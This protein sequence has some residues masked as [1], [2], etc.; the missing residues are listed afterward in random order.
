[1]PSN[2]SAL[3][4]MFKDVHARSRKLLRSHI[5]AGD[6]K[7]REIMDIS[8]RDQPTSDYPFVF[9]YAFCRTESDG[10]RIA[11]LSAGVNLLQASGFITDDIFDDSPRRYGKPSLHVRFG[12]SNAIIA[13]QMMQS[14]A[15]ESIS[16]ELDR[17]SFRNSIAA[18][19]MFNQIIR[20]LFIGQYLDVFHSGN[21]RMQLRD[22]TR[23]IALG[24]GRY[25]GHVA[26]CGALLA[27]KS[28]AEVRAFT[29]FGYH[30]GMAVF[31]TD[32]ILDI[33]AKPMRDHLIAGSDLMNRR[34]RLPMVFALQMAAKREAAKLRSFL[35][36]AGP[37]KVQQ[38]ASMAEIIEGSGALESC[39]SVA[40]R[41]VAASKRALAGVTD[42]LSRERLHWLA[43][44]LL[45]AQ[46]LERRA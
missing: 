39:R 32:D 16:E 19:R 21:I 37:P 13:A 23:V 24:V 34:M 28:P 40:L 41:H 27:G 22:Y 26:Q 38:L 15:L 11:G 6:G 1:M 29:R 46:G 33:K 10:A 35:K 17:G 3:R 43:A 42:P 8:I 20:E 2:L 45:R 12:V 25:Y 7:L 4:L 9:R 44:T 30:Y 14:I 18:L 36:S 5:A 31:I